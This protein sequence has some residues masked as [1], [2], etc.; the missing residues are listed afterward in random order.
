MMQIIACVIADLH[1]APIET[2]WE[3]DPGRLRGVLHAR[4]ADVSSARQTLALIWTATVPVALAATLLAAT[5]IDH[6]RAQGAAHTFAQVVTM[7]GVTISVAGVVLAVL[8]VLK[9][10]SP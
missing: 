4:P 1:L 8:G 10:Q 3:A 9:I 2:A 7:V 6:F 5:A